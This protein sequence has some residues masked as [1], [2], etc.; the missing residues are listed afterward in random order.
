MPD[1]RPTLP[2]S[3]PL[4]A[5]LAA[6]GEES[7]FDALMADFDEAARRLGIPAS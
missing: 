4:S 1:A 6:V 2:V 7:P 3:E 5:S